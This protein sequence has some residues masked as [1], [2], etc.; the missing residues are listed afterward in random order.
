MTYRQRVARAVAR[1][2]RD[3]LTASQRLELDL[4]SAVTEAQGQALVY[5]GQLQ[6]GTDGRL[7]ATRENQNRILRLNRLFLEWMQNA[8][9][10]SA[11]RRFFQSFDRDGDYMPPAFR[12]VWEIVTGELKTPLRLPRWTRGDIAAFRGI[13]IAAGVVIEDAIEAAGENAMKQLLFNVGGLS[14]DELQ[15]VILS[16]FR[17]SVGESRTLAATA[18]SSYYRTINARAFERIQEQADFELRY[19]FEGPIDK[20]TRPWCLK[21]AKA[22]KSGKSWTRPQIE[23]MRDDETRGKSQPPNVFVSCGGFNCRHQWVLSLNQEVTGRARSRS[24]R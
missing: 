10:D 3:I 16:Q 6:R 22:S 23:V 19:S 18:Q 11:L 14:V 5:L 12:E 13:K 7:L 17:R 20:L 4:I 24:Q 8:G 21:M 2:D 15:S 1:Q 9:L